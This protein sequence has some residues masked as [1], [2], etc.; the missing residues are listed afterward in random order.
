MA[1]FGANGEQSRGRA[2]QRLKPLQTLIIYWIPFDL[3]Q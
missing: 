1:Y 3:A 2:W